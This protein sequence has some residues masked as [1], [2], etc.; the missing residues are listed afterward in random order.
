[1]IPPNIIALGE[2]EAQLRAQSLDIIAADEALL[3]HLHMIEGAMAAAYAH[4]ISRPD[5][6]PDEL[7]IQ[8]LGIRLFNDLAS[9]LSQGLAGYYQQ[10]FDTLRDLVELQFL[11]DDFSG[12]RSRIARWAGIGRR[13]REREF[14]PR[15]VRER[16]DK[17]Y[18]HVGQKRRAV[19]QRF[20]TLASHASPEGFRL[21]APNG[22]AIIG[23]FIE[24]RFVRGLIE[25][26]AVVGLQAAINFTSLLPAHTDEERQA[27]QA[28]LHR[29]GPWLEKYMPDEV[30]AAVARN[31]AN[32][33]EA[34]E[35]A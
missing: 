2:H 34:G 17:R 25:E 7:T 12:D 33:R 35:K 5:R 28:F 29:G 14:S 19:Y 30:E 11:F 27:K 23:P 24:P 16:L 26:T 1:M 32:G 4:V 8:K 18:A 20:C 31:K 22:D 13:D 15:A 3:D 6:T 10:A 9:A 21:T